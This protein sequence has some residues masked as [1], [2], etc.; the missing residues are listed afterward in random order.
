MA[1]MKGP[2]APEARERV[3]SDDEIQAFWQAASAENW[4]V[5]S[6]LKMLLMTGQRRNEV[7]GMRWRELDLDAGTWTF[8]PDPIEDDDENW[9]IRRTVKNRK[10]HTVDLH[11]EVVRLLKQADMRSEDFVFSSTGAVPVN[12]FSAI[13]DRIDARMQ[14]ILGGKFQPWRLHRSEAH[15]GN[16]HGGAWLSARCGRQGTESRLRRVRRHRWHLSAA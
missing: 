6:V 12:S 9:R 11:P 3:L 5:S 13:K 8:A 4:P 7:A 2:K 10:S 15:S 16:R 1:A 14:A